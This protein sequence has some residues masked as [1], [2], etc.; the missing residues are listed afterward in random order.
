MSTREKYA[1][2]KVHIND[3]DARRGELAKE[4]C[5]A[6]N[7]QNV[8]VRQ[9]ILEEKLLQLTSWEME[10]EENDTVLHPTLKWEDP[11][12]E[13]LISLASVL[14]HSWHSSFE[15][16]DGISLELN[17]GNITLRFEDCKQVSPFIKSNELVVDRKHLHQR[18][19]ELKKQLQALEKYHAI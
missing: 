11:K 3:I 1:A 19:L 15:L 7:E 2:L 14:W 12:L 6:D 10:W 17:D 4:E 16:E 8:L 9:L 18:E 5:A 13:P